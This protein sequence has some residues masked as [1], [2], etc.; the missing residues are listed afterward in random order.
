MIKIAL[1]LILGVTIYANILQDAINSA[2]P[3]S[4]ISL[5]RGVYKGNIVIDKPLS[6]IAK[7]DGVIIQGENNGSTLKIKSSNVILKN[8]TITDS[9]NTMIGIDSAIQMYR[10][11]DCQIIGCRLINSLYGIDMAMVNNSVISDNYISS[12]DNDISLKG[13]GIKAWYSN[14]NIIQNNTFDKVR[15]VTFTRSHSNI[16]K[17]NIFTDNRFALHVSLS[18]KN[19]IK[20]NTFKFNSVSIMIMGAKDT[21]IKNNL[22]QSSKGAAGIG[23]VIKGVSNFLLKDNIIRYNA[24]GI[25]VDNKSS[26]KG[27]QRYFI[28]N[29]ISYNKEA[30]HFHAV[31]KN[32]TIKNNKIYA[33][34]EDIIKDIETIPTHA[35][36]IEYNYWDRYAGFDRDGDNIGDTPHR[37]YQYADK[38]WH[39]NNKIKF[40]YA[41]P[42]MSLLNFLTAVAPFVEPILL[43]EDK[44]P[45]VKPRN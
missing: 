7:E 2:E 14:N 45:V 35:N 21:V 19:K 15:D 5:N 12:K 10:V 29:D 18:H 39:Y 44:H 3:G 11:S 25:Y 13:D 24:Q 20:N 28:N 23:V 9:G 43:L 36:I 6:I 8:L 22:I 32:N 4:T 41:S 26:E 40:F 27:M 1:F 42:V 34:I 33:N 31:I 17:N 37:V 38:L 30:V 16:I